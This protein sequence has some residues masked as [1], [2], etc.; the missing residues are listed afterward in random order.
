M[1]GLNTKFQFSDI[2]CGYLFWSRVERSPPAPAREHDQGVPALAHRVAQQ[3]LATR[4]LLQKCQEGH[5]PDHDNTKPLCL[6]VQNKED[7]LHGQVR[8]LK[9]NATNCGVVQEPI[10]QVHFLV[11]QSDRPI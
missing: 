3:D 10:G 4:L 5:L 6:V 2:R 8:K 7:F 1:V 9:R 11:C